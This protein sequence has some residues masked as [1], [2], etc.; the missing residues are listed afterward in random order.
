MPTPGRSSPA[1]RPRARAATSPTGSPSRPPPPTATS[2]RST[3]SPPRAATCSPTSRPGRC[4]SRP[5]ER[6]AWRYSLTKEWS[7]GG[8]DHAFVRDYPKISGLHEPGDRADGLGHLLAGLVVTG[9]GGVDH[10]VVHV[11]LEQ[12]D[13]DRLEGL[14]HRGDLGQDVDAVLL[15]LDHPLQPAGLPLDAAQPLKV[16]VLAMD[17][18]VLVLRHTTQHT[19]AEYRGRVSGLLPG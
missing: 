1:A 9:A 12:A 3:S 16:V 13:R 18:A 14:R 19:R 11:L 8:F 5:V 7:P 4:S 17:V 15:V 10:A 2:S 6:A